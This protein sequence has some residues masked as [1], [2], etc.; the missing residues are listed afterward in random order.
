MAQQYL[1]VDGTDSIDA[2]KKSHM[3]K[4]YSFTTDDDDGGGS[5][6]KSQS[7]SKHDKLSTNSASVDSGNYED[8][9]SEGSTKLK[10]RKSRRITESENRSENKETSAK[11]HRP[12][13]KR[14]DW[15]KP[16]MIIGT[17]IIL[18][19]AWTQR[20]VWIPRLL[21]TN[22]RVRRSIAANNEQ[23]ATD[24][25]G[26]SSTTSLDSSNEQ[27]DIE[28]N[29]ND[30]DDGINSDNND[31]LT[32]SSTKSTPSS[33]KLNLRTRRNKMSFS[34]ESQKEKKIIVLHKIHLLMMMMI[35]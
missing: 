12:L 16:L 6:A 34:K 19:F 14:I 10:K 33:Q 1:T 22:N 20:D 23:T 3:I 4:T 31:D 15:V 29:D 24:L 28:D 21:T 18:Y 26:S 35:I 7:I 11:K 5:V 9:L 25:K 2:G 32:A 17:I 13:Y 27:D 30:N 8:D